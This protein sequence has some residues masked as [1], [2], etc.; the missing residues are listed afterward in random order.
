MNHAVGPIAHIWSPQAQ[1]AIRL[2]VS[3]SYFLNFLYET[4][5]IYTY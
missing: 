3:K 5:N 4:P 1:K 2:H